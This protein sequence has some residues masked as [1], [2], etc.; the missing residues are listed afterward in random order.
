[1]LKI[2]ASKITP[3]IKYTFNVFF[4]HLIP[5][6][7]HIT[8]DK[9]E[10]LSH[11]G[12]KI[13]YGE[14]FEDI[15]Y[16]SAS[17]FLFKK[18]IDF[19]EPKHVI[20]EDLQGFF[21]VYDKRSAFSFDVFA[22]SFY[23]FSR[24]EEYLPFVKDIHGRF[25]AKESILFRY[26]MLDR[27]WV[28]IYAINVKAIILNAYPDEEFKLTKYKFIPTYDID[29]AFA[30]KEKGLVRWFGGLIK[31]I[32]HKEFDK[33]KDRLK[34]SLGKI[35]DPFDTF[36]Y[37]LQ[38]QKDYELDVKYFILFGD[39]GNYDKNIHINNE[40]FKSLIKLLSDYAEVGI[41]PSYQSNYSE[42][43]LEREISNLSS[44]LHRDIVNSRQHFLKKNLPQTYRNL[45]NLDIKND[46]T[47]GYATHTGFRAGV[48][49]SYPF[50]DIESE[51]ET[52]L[53]IHP[54]AV[55]DCTLKSYMKLSQ[56]EALENISKLIDEVKKVH[57]T[58]IS[59]WHN[60]TLSDMYE[61]KG[62]KIVYAQLVKMALP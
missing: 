41:H 39:H 30:H 27:P 56:E 45:I 26:N 40:T 49:S 7:F 6:K 14:Y 58:F 19:F 51:S 35:K 10:F 3:R 5:I 62:W 22:A 61:W 52:N 2:F 55:M 60:E 9:E 4:K 16:F 57:G 59:L 32:I 23:L 12:T 21:P 33:A 24:Y 8:N 18:G 25:E 11:N 50:Y 31:S 43:I 20:D 29:S 37:Q 1:M 38:L 15:P 53:M 42:T 44:V 48:C 54:F 17:D 36:D 28:N 47:M 46:Y 34:T 13:S